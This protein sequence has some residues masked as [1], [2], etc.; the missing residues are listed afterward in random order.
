MGEITIPSVDADTT[1]AAVEDVLGTG[2]VIAFDDEAGTA[3]VT[4]ATADLSV[5]DVG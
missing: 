3:T 4:S 1:A 2:Y 5:L